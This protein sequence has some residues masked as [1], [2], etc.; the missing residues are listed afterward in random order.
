MSTDIAKK[1]YTYM[2][3]SQLT[4]GTECKKKRHAQEHTF[5]KSKTK[6]KGTNEEKLKMLVGTPVN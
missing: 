4:K 6:P 1:T 3:S 2:C 5:A